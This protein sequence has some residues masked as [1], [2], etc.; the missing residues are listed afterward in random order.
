MNTLIDL[1]KKVDRLNVDAHILRIDPYSAFS[2]GSVT[3]KDSPVVVLLDDFKATACPSY[4]GP[5]KVVW[6]IKINTED[7]GCANLC[8]TIKQIEET[9]KNEIPNNKEACDFIQVSGK[10][11]IRALLD[12]RISP[13]IKNN[14]LEVKIRM[15]DI[16][17]YFGDCNDTPTNIKLNSQTLN[18]FF[19]K[20]VSYSAHISLSSFALLQKTGTIKI[21]PVVS[22]IIIKSDINTIKK[23][24]ISKMA[25][26]ETVSYNK[27]PSLVMDANVFIKYRGLS[28]ANMYNVT[29]IKHQT[30]TCIPKSEITNYNV[31]KHG[32]VTKGKDQ[33]GNVIEITKIIKH[34]PFY[35][36]IHN[37]ICN[38]KGPRDYKNNKKFTMCFSVEDN[39]EM[40]I[41]IDFI[42]DVKGYIIDTIQDKQNCLTIL[43]MDKI[44]RRKKEERTKQR[45]TL[46][47][48]WNDNVKNN[49]LKCKIVLGIT[50]FIDE[51][52]NCIQVNSNNIHQ[53]LSHSNMFDITVEV[54]GFY[55][56][57]EKMGIQVKLRTLKSCEDS[58]TEFD[59]FH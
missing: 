14:I 27:L 28:S 22:N 34:I 40:N 31:K 37:V 44:S 50:L 26:K 57:K 21:L 51:N 17:I 25:I 5:N 49:E 10:D 58:L 18:I 11:D 48:L 1:N 36:D 46:E 3:I 59:Y 4:K 35:I 56:M 20:N 43:N 16:K 12:T 29:S 53:L 6:K 32:K 15:E 52:D 39:D 8:K 23:R 7:E 30:I 19:R 24:Y 9:I 2:V 42:K 33:E 41:F 55:I 54:T 47:S 38:E 45:D 13:A